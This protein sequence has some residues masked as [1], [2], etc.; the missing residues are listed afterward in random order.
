MQRLIAKHFGPLH[1]VDLE[2]RDFMVLIGQQ[3]LWPLNRQ[4]TKN[5]FIG[6]LET[7]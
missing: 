2:I 4:I 5:F 7:A 6:N 3:M 1:N